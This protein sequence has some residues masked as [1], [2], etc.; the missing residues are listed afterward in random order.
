VASYRCGRCGYSFEATSQEQYAKLYAEH[1]GPACLAVLG[2][3]SGDHVRYLIND[4]GR[5]MDP[6]NSVE[7]LLRVL[8]MLAAHKDTL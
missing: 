5:L 1:T 4:I 3:M 7:Q 2:P 8:E 6:H